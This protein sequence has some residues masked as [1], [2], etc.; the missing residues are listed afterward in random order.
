MK[1]IKRAIISKVINWKNNFRRILI[2]FFIL[3]IPLGIIISL[4]AYAYFLNAKKSE[5][6]MQQSSVKENETN[7]LQE[8]LI[9]EQKEVVQP[10]IQESVPNY[11]Q[12]DIKSW[13]DTLSSL[14]KAQPGWQEDNK[15]TKNDGF[16]KDNK[17]DIKRINVII[18]QRISNIQ[19]IL[20]TMKANNWITSAE[21]KMITD[22]TLLYN[23]QEAI[24]GRLSKRMDDLADSISDYSYQPSIYTSPTIT[25][26]SSTKPIT[27][28]NISTGSS[29]TEKDCER[30]FTS[31]VNIG[32][33]SASQYG[34]SSAYEMAISA[35]IKSCKKQYKCNSYPYSSNW[36]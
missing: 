2:N 10:P 6:S 1:N 27:S 5:S 28:T 20:A 3:V 8:A 4:G 17:T 23:E 36:P 29:Y 11:S 12:A 31:C 7:F 18:S 13:A 35:S 30:D 22:D 14:K 26:P 9:A 19:Q 24:A 16:Y 32:V 21:Q 15:K 33:Q 34:N 25:P